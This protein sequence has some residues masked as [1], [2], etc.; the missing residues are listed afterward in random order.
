MPPTVSSAYSFSYGDKTVLVSKTAL[1]DESK[2]ASRCPVHLAFTCDI[3]GSMKTIVSGTYDKTRWDVVLHLLNEMI[4]ERQQDGHPQDRVSV[5]CY[6]D[7]AHLWLDNMPLCRLNVKEFIDNH[8]EIDERVTNIEVGQ[9]AMFKILVKDEMKER[10]I[11]DI[12]FTDG[13][14]NRGKTGPEELADDKKMHY[15][16]LSRLGHDVFV[17]SYA[18]SNGANPDLSTAVTKRV[19]NSAMD[20][21]VL[22]NEF[23]ELAGE[24]GSVMGMVDSLVTIEVAPGRRELVPLNKFATT[25][26]DGDVVGL[27]D[28]EV[29]LYIPLNKCIVRLVEMLN[30]LLAVGDDGD[31]VKVNA[32][33][34][35]MAEMKFDNWLES[36]VEQQ[37]RLSIVGEHLVSLHEN[38]SKLIDNVLEGLTI[39]PTPSLLREMSNSDAAQ[40]VANRYRRTY[41]KRMGS[42]SSSSSSSSST[43]SSFTGGPTIEVIDDIP[44][45]SNNTAIPPPSK[46]IRTH[47]R[48]RRQPNS[49]SSSSVKVE[50]KEEND[51]GGGKRQKSGNKCVRF[52]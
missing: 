25:L 19:G 33:K 40:V 31:E 39:T 36:A 21:H 51:N 52:K 1:I 17:F 2:A 44:S 46:L 18:I 26:I 49:S 15:D 37:N 35:E 14:P 22:D 41:R 12:S 30:A 43:S 7:T 24:F 34:V 3:S 29:C 38:V 48:R 13:V 9:N 11:I 47:R 50:E 20:R 28:N 23:H 5:V 4:S 45:S 8:S 27:D 16:T 6:N 10:K 32:W 42:S